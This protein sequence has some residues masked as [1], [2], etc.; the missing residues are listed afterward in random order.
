MRVLP[1]KFHDLSTPL[2]NDENSVSPAST[3]RPAAHMNYHCLSRW[4]R[5]GGGA[6]GVWKLQG[7]GLHELWMSIGGRDFSRDGDDGGKY[8]MS[9][10]GSVKTPPRQMENLG[11]GVSARSTRAAVRC[12]SAGECS[13]PT[14]TRFRSTSTARSARDNRPSSMS[15]RSRRT[16]IS[17]TRMSASTRP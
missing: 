3:V 7:R 14:R 6:Q 17:P 10:R 1:C 16:P 11:R 15:R 4:K 13:A 8:R 5:R 2:T 12:S 9:L